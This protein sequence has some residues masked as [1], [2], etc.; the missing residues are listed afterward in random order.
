MKELYMK[1]INMVINKFLIKIIVLFFFNFLIFQTSTQSLENKILYKIDNK[2]ITSIDIKEEIN[3]LIVLNPSLKK[4][5]K[6]EIIEISKK[7]LIKE[8]IK[9]IEILKNFEKPD[10]PDEILEQFIKNIY[11]NIG[12]SNL[13]EFQNYLKSNQVDFNEVKSKIQIEVL[14]NE[15]IVY[16]FSNK[17]KIDE[18]KIRDK[19]KNNFNKKSKSYLLSEILF[20]VSKDENLNEK[21]IMISK[22]ISDTGFN[23]TALIYSIS[24]SANIGGKLG[25]ID[26]KSLNEKISNELISLKN[27]EITK[28]IRVPGGFLILQVNDTKFI[29]NNDDIEKEISKTIKV[30]QNN[31]YKQF[32]KLYFNRIKKNM[33]INEI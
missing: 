29:K 14:W 26:G 3:Y 8:K 19:V 33:E 32:S 16:K 17:L 9:E 28:P 31:Q 25:W 18:E 12:F 15:L 22:S 10:V 20:E 23:N 11:F 7:S 5:S 21:Y 30:S 1:E 2:I 6:S 24:E 4:L 13:S 27:K